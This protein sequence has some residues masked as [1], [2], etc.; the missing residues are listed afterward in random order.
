[1]LHIHSD[2]HFMKLAFAEAEQAFEVGEIPVGAVV[3]MGSR[4]IAKAHNQ[5]EMLNDVTAHAEM[6]AITAAQNYV[7]S[8]YLEEASIYVTLEPCVMC[9]G[10][11]FWSQIG[12]VIIGARD[13]ARGY[14]RVKPAI[15][16]PKTEVQFGL[17]AQ[18]S[19][20]LIKHFFKNIRGNNN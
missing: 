1:M 15:I 8:K 5:V 2:E 14:S 20:A 18:E 4:V 10:A 12:R 6:L 9:A 19:E 17:M 3:T 16:H 7:G 13:D 11:L